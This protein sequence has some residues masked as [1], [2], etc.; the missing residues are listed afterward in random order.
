MVE[1]DTLTVKTSW[2]SFL[3]QIYT[4]GRRPINGSYDYYAIEEKAREVTKDNNRGADWLHADLIYFSHL[5]MN[6]RGR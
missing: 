1:D 3:A 5:L 2:S 6:I 4:T